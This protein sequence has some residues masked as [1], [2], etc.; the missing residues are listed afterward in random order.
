MAKKEIKP[1]RKQKVILI[2]TFFILVFFSLTLLAKTK[3]KNSTP[4]L[5]TSI[6]FN[7]QMVGGKYQ[8]PF[9]AL[10]IVE[11]EKSIDDLI[12][13]RKNFQDRQRRSKVMR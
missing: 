7:D 4:S 1:L 3:N 2:F 5:S 13:V 11:D 10:T 12:G 9:E 6:N 8:S